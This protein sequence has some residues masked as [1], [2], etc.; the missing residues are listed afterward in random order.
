MRNKISWRH[1]NLNRIGVVIYLAFG[2][3]TIVKK[4]FIK[5]ITRR[6]K[7]SAYLDKLNIPGFLFLNQYT[8]AGS[9]SCI[10][11]RFG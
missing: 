3:S 11:F 7:C 5:N 1:Q 6:K 10:K 2:F 8:L 9:V 4:I